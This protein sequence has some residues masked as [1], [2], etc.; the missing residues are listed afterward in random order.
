M[1]Q[2]VCLVCVLC[3]VSITNAQVPSVY[4]TTEKTTSLIFPHPI[5]HVDRG[6]AD[7][8]AEPVKDAANILL[9]KAAS[10]DLTETNVSVV[11]KDGSLYSFRICYAEE[12]STWVYQIPVQKTPS[13]LLTAQS[14]LDNP[15]ILKGVHQN[16]FNVEVRLTGIYVQND[17]LF[18][19][20][21]LQND[22]PLDYGID[23]LRF[24]IRDRYVA[25]RTAVQEIDY[26]PL[27]IAGPH[28]TVKAGSETVMVVAL[29]KFTV[30]DSQDFWLQVGEEGGGR[31]LQLKVSG[32]KLSKAFVVPE[33]SE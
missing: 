10:K 18:F 3:I 31:Q 16:S 30:N 4:L 21:H 13:V 17:H 12:P 27:F 9:L 7:V 14:L 8:L 22:S 25:K 23:L 29:K 1:K 15:P 5:I 24:F 19:Q 33:R 32:R 11:T 6:R 28:T 2:F 26:T 20:L